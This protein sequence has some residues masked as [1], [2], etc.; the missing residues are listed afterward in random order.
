TRSQSVS[1][2]LKE[3]QTERFNYPDWLS[4]LTA[5]ELVEN[6][7][8]PEFRKK[9]RELYDNCLIKFGMIH[10][11]TDPYWGD[12]FMVVKCAN[13]AYEGKLISEIAKVKNIDELE[14]VFDI[15]VE[16][17]ESKWVAYHDRRYNQVA[18]SEFLKHPL[19]EPCTDDFVLPAKVAH[20]GVETDASSAV[21]ATSFG[22]YPYY[23]RTYVKELGILSLEEAVKKATSLPTK[24]LGLNRGVLQKGA[25]ADVVVFDFD[26]IDMKVDF[27]EPDQQP[28]GI[29]YVLV[30]GKIAYKDKKHTGEKAGKVLRKSM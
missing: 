4:N 28:E 10:T 19:C 9:I 20:L 21:T 30:N 6:L 26:R 25:Y 7:K 1:T 14:A 22:M 3:F 12:C 17:P 16:D 15:I 8:E 29:E 11:K 24:R 2:M 23:I 27:L 18:V 13:T 5:E